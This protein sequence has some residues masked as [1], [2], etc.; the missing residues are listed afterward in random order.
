M[1][2][3]F[4]IFLSILGIILLLAEFFLI[5]GI[6]IAGIGGFLSVVLSVIFAF[7][8]K[9]WFGYIITIFNVISLA[10]ILYFLFRKK[11]FDKIGLQEVI[12][13][14]FLVIDKEKIKEGD[15]GIT[16]TRLNPVGKVLVNNVLYEAKSLD[17]TYI[18]QNKDIEIV[19]IVN[20]QLIVKLKS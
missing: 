17:G 2:P 8:F 20:N 14:K 3:L 11:T 6:S 12:N 19:K 1:S 7:K 16:V 10:I 13:G 5:P 4:I 9:I 15:V 18:E